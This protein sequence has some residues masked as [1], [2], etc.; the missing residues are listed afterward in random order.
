MIYFAQPIEGGPVKIGFTSDV[1]ARLR[2]L[3]VY[4]GRP[5]A[6]LGIMEG[7]RDEERSI[8]GRFAHLRFG[9]TEQFRP[10][11]DLM[12]FIGRPLLV[13]ANPYATEV[14]LPP[15]FAIINLKG[16]QEQADWLEAAHRKTHI[17]K[18]VIVRLALSQWAGSNGLAPF[19]P[20]DSDEEQ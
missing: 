13:G 16:T 3:E 20:L 2:Q 11:A 6:L 7:D 19:P 4:Y 1:D 9:R 15:K 12:A 17:A 14:L 5:L 18:S 8:H 10:A